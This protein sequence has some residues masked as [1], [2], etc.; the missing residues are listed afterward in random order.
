MPQPSKTAYECYSKLWR[1]GHQRQ[2]SFNNANSKRNRESWHRQEIWQ[3]FVAFDVGLMTIQLC[4]FVVDQPREWIL[5]VVVPQALSFRLPSSTWIKICFS[6]FHIAQSWDKLLCWFN[7]HWQ[8]YQISEFLFT[9]IFPFLKDHPLPIKF[10]KRHTESQFY[11]ILVYARFCRN[12]LF[13][14]C[15]KHLYFLMFPYSSHDIHFLTTPVSCAHFQAG[16][17]PKPQQWQHQILN[18]C[19]S[20]EG[21]AMVFLY[22]K[23]GEERVVRKC[24]S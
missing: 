14:G 8:L 24:G 12:T 6:S 13:S 3:I 23:Y 17:E 1:K 20:R 7:I 9:G 19:T 16:M 10:Y 2:N 18:C 4:G 11:A 5:C 21:P 15:I 22:E